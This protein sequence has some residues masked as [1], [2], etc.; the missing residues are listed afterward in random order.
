MSLIGTVSCIIFY[1]QMLGENPPLFPLQMTFFVSQI[2]N[3]HRQQKIKII[4]QM[5]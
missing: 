2:Y 5:T 3:K 4:N 1:L